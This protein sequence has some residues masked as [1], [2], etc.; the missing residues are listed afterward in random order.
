MGIR[1]AA[2]SAV[3]VSLGLNEYQIAAQKTDLTGQSQEDAILVSVLGIAGESGDLATLFKKR[4]RDGD[5]FTVYPEQCAE[6]LGDILWY[7]SNVST[8][9]GFTLEE[10]AK[11]NLAKT[12]SRWGN[13]APTD[14]KRRLLD[15]EYKPSEQIPRVFTVKFEESKR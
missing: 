1:S 15:E 10:I 13:F 5:S 2:R 6:E 3:N 8:K 7:V 12:K 11:R 14:Q 4:L 9:L